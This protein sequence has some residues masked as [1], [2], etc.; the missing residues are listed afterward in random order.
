MKTV[1]RPPYPKWNPGYFPCSS[2]TPLPL[3]S[4]R[5]SVSFGG[6]GV[7]LTGLDTLLAGS[8]FVSIHA[9]LT[10]E[11]EGLI[12]GRRLAMMRPSAY[13]LNL[14]DAAIVAEEALVAAMREGR[15]AGAALDV[16]D[17]YPLR[18][19]SPLL[20]LDNAIL[21]PHLGGATEETVRRHSA[22]MA[23]DILRFAA[24]ER[25]INLVNP[26]TWERRG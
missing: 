26:D 23:E 5:P 10:S 3:S 17:T 4:R 21:T 11:T 12:D 16:F 13:L 14:A 18:P 20:T 15:I 22:Q 24:G 6:F 2:L 7:S 8:D 19:D 25:P 1:R 9:P